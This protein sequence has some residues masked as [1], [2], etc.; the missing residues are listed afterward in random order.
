MLL[1][2]IKLLF[3]YNKVMQLDHSWKWCICP[4]W[5]IIVVGMKLIY[6]DRL[7]YQNE[8]VFDSN[9]QLDHSCKWPICPNWGII[10]DGIKLIYI[11]RLGYHNKGVFDWN[12]NDNQRST[13]NIVTKRYY[14]VLNYMFSIILLIMPSY[15]Q[16]CIFLRKEVG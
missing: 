13:S 5:G 16:L 11:D 2:A 14:F 10:V 12:E 3:V 9:M 4:N 8:G 15:L 6:I 1:V 7:G